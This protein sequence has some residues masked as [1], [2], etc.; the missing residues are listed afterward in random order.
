M[1]IAIG[2]AHADAGDLFVERF[3][4]FA[5]KFCLRCHN[6]EKARGELDLTRYADA[7]KVAADFRRWNDVIEFIRDGEM[8]PDD[9][10][11]PTIE[12]RKVATQALEAI[13]LKEARKHAGD[14]GVVPQRRLSNTEYDRSVRDLTGVDIRPTR[15]FPP[16][17]AGGEGFDN[18]GEAL[19]M[20]PS[21]LKKYLAA[22]QHVSEHM[23]LKT[24]GIAFAPFAVT[25]YNEQKKLTEQA[26]IDFYQ[27]H[28]VKVADYLEACWRFRHRGAADRELQIDAWARRSGLSSKYLTLV[29]ETLSK[30]SQSSGYL[31][32]VGELWEAIPAPTEAAR[33]PELAALARF[34]EFCQQRLCYREPP[35]IHAS[36]GNW[37]I[38]HLDLR[39]RTAAQR[40]QFGP[41]NLKKTATVR[42]DRLKALPENAAEQLTLYL[43]FDRAFGDE[44][45]HGL[46]ALRRPVFSKAN[47]PPRNDDEVKQHEAVTLRAVL[48]QHTPVIAQRLAFGKHPNGEAI[49]ADTC[50]IQAPALVEIPFTTEMLRQ[51]DGKQLF[52]ECEFLEGLGDGGVYVLPGVGKPPE[53]RYAA[54]VELLLDPNGNLA[55]SMA[56]S[57]AEFCRTFPNRFV[58]VDNERGLAAGFHLV[59]GFFRDD[60]PFVEKVLDEQQ[61]REL[62]GLWRELDFVTQSTETLL[63]GF[64]W[65]ERSERHVLH[66]KRFDFLRPEDPRLVDDDL[67]TQFEK[68]YLDKLGVKL[69]EGS[70]EPEKPNSQ[71]D[72]IH[73]FFVR[74]RAGLA[75]YREQLKFAEQ[76][77]LADL[78]TLA[79]RAFHRPL[80]SGDSKSLRTLYD[81]LRGR[82]QSVEASLRGA[83]TAVLM[84]PDFFFHLRSPPPGSGVHSLDAYALASRLSYF[85]WSSLPDEELLAAARAHKLQDD[86]E[87]MAQTRR[88]LNDP[89]IDA[90]GRE[91]FG[92]WL[93]YRDYLSKDPINAAAFPGYDDRLREAMF[94]EPVRLTTYLIQRD[95]PVTELLDSDVTFVNGVLARY[96]GGDLAR[97]YNS[98]S[99]N[100]ADWHQ[101]SGLRG[102]GRGGLIG[103][104]VVLTKTSKG[105]RTSP[106]KRGFWA[107]HHLLGQHFPPPPADVPELPANEKRAA[108]T[109]RELMAAHTANARCAMCHIH[110][111]SL[112]LALEGFDPIG[113]ARTND[114][115]GRPI[116]NAAVLPSGETAQGIPGL[117]DYIEGHRR[118][119]FV[120]TLCRKFLG[121]ALGRSVLLS[122]Q[123][124]L[125]EMETALEKNEYRF[126]VLFETVVRSQ[127]FRKQRGGEFVATD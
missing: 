120:G 70:L 15:D 78:D 110:F 52:V 83:F 34:I 107:V 57:S 36:A 73:G 67:L 61:Q 115:A 112:G 40:D 119:D 18:T 35:L 5:E 109:I 100:P 71:Y 77:A 127:Q 7:G 48:E 4:P 55:K 16:D 53:D 42:F 58:Y 79:E 113:R 98:V 74:I 89:R 12:E 26:I 104:G 111:D 123:S 33:P 41:S 85:L 44:G 59:E 17:P 66:D 65:F 103:M 80:T 50:V 39:A 6:R 125:T 13:L 51:V 32:Q 38:G 1:A 24:G 124:L 63:R 62:D 102:Q 9:E 60:R 114:L 45:E 25:S 96:Y 37:P 29:W 93:R 28:A 90:F 76:R 19:G 3:Q 10:P 47:A 86:A 95:R 126:S 121:Y 92:Q 108:K 105:E 88:M 117:I 82:G 81:D 43:R 91:F 69:I 8:P 75:L 54:N 99:A 2:V 11:Q 116:D 97:Q 46:V 101:V 31:K 27:S 22:A 56:E 14:P 84:S 23:V 20:S 122:D 72:L 118:R 30:A 68:V 106:V 49:D 64:V 94:D 21:L 87:L